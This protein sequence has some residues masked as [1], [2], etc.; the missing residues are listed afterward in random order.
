MIRVEGEVIQVEKSE[1][2][3]DDMVRD[4]RHCLRDETKADDAN[5]RL[6]VRRDDDDGGEDGG[7]KKPIREKQ[8]TN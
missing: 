5:F 2:E 8:M 6:L 3:T 1:T 4:E 7:A